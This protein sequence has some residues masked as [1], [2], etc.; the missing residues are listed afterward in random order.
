[1][2]VSRPIE[3][4]WDLLKL[5]LNPCVFIQP[6]VYSI[7]GINEKGEIRSDCNVNVVSK[8]Y[9]EYSP[10]PSIKERMQNDP[11][12]RPAE[13]G[14]KNRKPNEPFN[15]RSETQY[16][17]GPDTYVLQYRDTDFPL[18]IREYLRVGSS[19]SPS[20]ASNLREGHWGYA[21]VSQM[22]LGMSFDLCGIFIESLFHNNCRQPCERGSCCMKSVVVGDLLPY[23]P[24]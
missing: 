7:V 20:L 5:G 16:Q 14:L 4:S 1:M 21:H 15:F 18:R 3:F 13:W 2:K 6:G 17:I 8:Y 23:R 22:S 9:R 10:P 19:R 11:N 24:V 12:Y